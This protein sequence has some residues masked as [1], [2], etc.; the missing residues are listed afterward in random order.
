MN[1]TE[2]CTGLRTRINTQRKDERSILDYVITSQ[3]MKDRIQKMHIDEEGLYVPARYKARIAVETD[4]K[5]IMVTI[6]T[7]KPKEEECK[8]PEQQRWILVKED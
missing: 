8:V 1:A 3:K 7:D 5:P 6:N 4:H 2:K